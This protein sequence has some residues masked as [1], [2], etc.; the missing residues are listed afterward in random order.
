MQLKPLLLLP[1]LFVSKLLFA[2][3]SLTNSSADLTDRSIAVVT[4][5]GPIISTVSFTDCPITTAI[6]NFARRLEINYSI[7]PFG[8]QRLTGSAADNIPEPVITIHVETVDL[9]DLLKR[10]LEL[11]RFVMIADPVSGVTRITSPDQATNI[12][13]VSLLGMNTNNSTMFSNDITEIQMTDI[14]LDTALE[15]LIRRSGLNITLDPRV[16]YSNDRLDRVPTISIRW[17]N[18]SAKQAIVALCL[19]YHLAIVKDSSSGELRIEPDSF[20]K[21]HHF[22]RP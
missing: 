7:D 19:N 18:I 10:M 8:T 11:R 6:E 21:P 14:S 15:H 20:R 22:W 13:D 9:K 5:G 3:V 4:N 2:E 17:K 16:Q 1:C 12:V